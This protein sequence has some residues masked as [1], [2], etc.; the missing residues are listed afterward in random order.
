M[1]LKKTAQERADEYQENSM[2]I[3]NQFIEKFQLEEESLNRKVDNSAKQSQ[4][5]KREQDELK[6][7]DKIIKKE[8]NDFE[9]IAGP[10]A[11]NAKMVHDK[12]LRTITNMRKVS[13]QH[14]NTKN[15]NQIFVDKIE[16]NKSIVE[17]QMKKK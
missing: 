16:E 14:N 4:L 9:D 11:T 8:Q 2:R 3:H 6:K 12:I 17:K 7:L 13:S 10:G 15:E 5:A 1:D